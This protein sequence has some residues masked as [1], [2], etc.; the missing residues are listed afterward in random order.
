MRT[1][2]TWHGAGILLGVMAIGLWT[3]SAFGQPPGG[4]GAGWGHPTDEMFL[5]QLVQGAGLTETQQ[6]QVRQ[7]VASH[8]PKFETLRRQLRSAREQLA[9]KL[10]VPGPVKAE[11]LAPLIQQIGKL[12][13]PLMHESLQVA[14]EVR[15]LLTPEQLAKA[16]Q[17]RQRLN[18]IRAEMRK[19]LEEGH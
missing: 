17:R 8:R 6:A 3:A 2:K 16:K 19:L 13:E 11:D 14:L 5:L 4:R 15:K 18:E 9:E 7:I 12:R 1:H 10:Y